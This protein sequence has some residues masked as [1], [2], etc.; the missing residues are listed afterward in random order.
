MRDKYKYEGGV[1]S[2]WLV[3]DD[4]VSYSNNDKAGLVPG[5]HHRGTALEQHPVEKPLR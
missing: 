2:G 4:V 3:N 5:Q 1:Q